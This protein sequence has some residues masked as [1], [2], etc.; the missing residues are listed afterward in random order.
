LSG[1]FEVRVALASAWETITG[2]MFMEPG[3]DGDGDGVDVDT[4]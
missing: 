3:D 1:R 2:L 4:E